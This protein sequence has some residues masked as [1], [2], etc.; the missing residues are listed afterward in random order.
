MSISVVLLAESEVLK[1]SE[2]YQAHCL[3]GWLLVHH[4]V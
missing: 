1:S 2:H 3:T 4:P